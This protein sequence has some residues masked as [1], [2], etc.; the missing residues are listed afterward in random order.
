M[1]L[2]SRAQ[3]EGMAACVKVTPINGGDGW[4]TADPLRSMSDTNT[5]PH[6]RAAT[7]GMI[8][9]G[10]PNRAGGHDDKPIL[11]EPGGASSDSSSGTRVLEEAVRPN[12]EYVR[13]TA[14]APCG[15]LGDSL[16]RSDGARTRE[17]H[18]IEI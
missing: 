10:V 7:R 17:R 4:A 5:I 2:K 11:R 6:L 14:R 8:A 12:R 16:R 3:P 13:T 18:P 15:V 1:P 9:P